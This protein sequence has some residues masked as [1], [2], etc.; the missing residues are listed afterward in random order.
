MK[1]KDILQQEENNTENILLYKEG[2]FWRA[3]EKSAYLFITFVKEFKIT[4]R[5]FRNV[6]TEIVYLGFPANSL[7]SILK[8]VGNKT[9]AKQEKLITISNFE[10]DAD[11]FELWKSNIKVQNK[12]VSNNQNIEKRIIN[13]SVAN[14]TPIECQQFLIELQN[15]IQ[16]L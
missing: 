1:I 10:Y 2:M 15:E 7:N 13:F 9:V 4:K 6:N 8:I 12:L 16:T 3:Y 5:Y 11:K 14:K